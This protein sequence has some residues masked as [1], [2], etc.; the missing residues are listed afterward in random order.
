[1]VFRFTIVSDESDDFFREIK[2]DAD[3]TFLDFCQAILKSCGYSDNQVT[4]FYI[5]DEEWEKRCEITREDMG[6]SS[7]GYDEDIYIMADTTLR[8]LID[9][10]PQRLKFIFDTFNNR[11]FFIELKEIIPSEHLD[12]PVVS[13]SIGNAPEQVIV[14]KEESNAKKKTP[15][16]DDTF[17]DENFYGSDEFNEDDLSN[18]GLDISDDLQF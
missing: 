1:M 13:R 12:A 9:D 5:T 16:P 2:I 18:E 7:Y 4:S 14:P 8:S 17:S 11:G 10:T 6:V 3:A 15:A